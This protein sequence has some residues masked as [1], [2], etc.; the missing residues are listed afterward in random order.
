MDYIDDSNCLEI[1]LDAIEY[2]FKEIKNKLSNETKMCMVLKS[3]AYGHGAVKL[4]KLYED[5]GADFLQ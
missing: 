3:N 4:A 5:L 2:N 1:D